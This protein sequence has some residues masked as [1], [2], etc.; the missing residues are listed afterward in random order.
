MDFLAFMFGVMALGMFVGAILAV[1]KAA[2]GRV[3]LLFVAALLMSGAATA[4][5][6]A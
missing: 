5:A 3:A 1:T 2:W 6:V 4:V